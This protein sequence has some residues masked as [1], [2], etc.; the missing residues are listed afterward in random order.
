MIKCKDSI[1]P[2]MRPSTVSID[3]GVDRQISY[4]RHTESLL[5]L[6]SGEH[7]PDYEERSLFSERLMSHTARIATP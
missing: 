4:T 2:I 3:R 6:C 7:N 5:R 1:N